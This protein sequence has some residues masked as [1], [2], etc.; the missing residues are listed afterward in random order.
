MTTLPAHLLP[1]SLLT[2]ADYCGEDVMWAI[3]ENYGGGRLHVPMTATPE[4]KLSDLLGFANAC[5]FCEQFGGEMLTIAK[6]DHARRAVRNELIRQARREG[7]DNLT[8]ARR[9]NL[10]D[11]QIMQICKAYAPAVMNFDLFE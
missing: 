6:A 7:I 4:H 11:R 3:W 10:T 5:R 1:Q 8:L 9:F 2:I